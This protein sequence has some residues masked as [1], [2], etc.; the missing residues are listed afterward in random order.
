MAPH[1]SEG[2]RKNAACSDNVERWG[3]W[4]W[5]PHM[6][7][8]ARARPRI[9]VCSPRMAQHSGAVWGRG[10]YHTELV[11][12]VCCADRDTALT[13]GPCIGQRVNVRL[14]KRSRAG[15]KTKQT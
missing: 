12:G 14:V 7:H 15:R 2:G 13:D 4:V 10:E 11:L 3:V 1:G 6:P 5:C 9:V 8:T